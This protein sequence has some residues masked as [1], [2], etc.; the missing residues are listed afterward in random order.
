MDG[1]GD[2][3]HEHSLVSRLVKLSEMDHIRPVRIESGIRGR[4]P[5]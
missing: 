1:T 4:M 2:K 5:T 3:I